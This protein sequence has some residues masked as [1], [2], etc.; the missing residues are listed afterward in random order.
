MCYLEADFSAFPDA[1]PR[2]EEL[3]SDGLVNLKGTHLTVPSEH[4]LFCRSVAQ[5]FDAHYTGQA[6]RHAKA[7]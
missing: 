1:L 7:V 2:L 4:S 3:A 5:A 6:G